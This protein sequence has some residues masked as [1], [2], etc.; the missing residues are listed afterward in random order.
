[1][2]QQAVEPERNLSTALAKVGFSI[3]ILSSVATQR[4]F[5]KTYFQ[6]NLVLQILAQV[7]IAYRP[8]LSTLKRQGS[9]FNGKIL[10]TAI[11]GP[12][13]IRNKKC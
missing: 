9:R 4:T 11:A 8:R 7:S 1:M 2:H 10:L 5:F 12:A 13:S 6:Q 3:S